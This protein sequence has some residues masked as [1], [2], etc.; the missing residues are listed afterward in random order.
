MAWV[1]RWGFEGGEGANWE[2]GS[3]GVVIRVC[4]QS[5]CSVVSG[6]RES[7]WSGQLSSGV[8]RDH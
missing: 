2:T 8:G 7:H 4:G 3:Q 5:D 6:N 1:S